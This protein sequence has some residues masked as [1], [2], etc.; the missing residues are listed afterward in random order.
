MFLLEKMRNMDEQIDRASIYTWRIHH[1]AQKIGRD[2][3][4]F[5][6]SMAETDSFLRDIENKV[7]AFLPINN[8]D[9]DKHWF[10][11]NVLDS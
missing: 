9:D 8:D 5:Q 10:R 4:R 3:H 7:F 1:N 2:V 6:Q 11:L